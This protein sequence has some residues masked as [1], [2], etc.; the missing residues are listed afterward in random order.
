MIY[1]YPI[2]PKLLVSGNALNWRPPMP[3]FRVVE[4]PDG[5]FYSEVLVDDDLTEV[6]TDYRLHMMATAVKAATTQLFDKAVADKMAPELIKQDQKIDRL[7]EALRQLTDV[8]KKMQTE[9]R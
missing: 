7:T 4:I 8:L 1:Q 6:T 5:K 3:T 2:I 9:G